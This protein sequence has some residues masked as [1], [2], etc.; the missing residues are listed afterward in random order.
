[1][2][3]NLPELFKEKAEEVSSNVFTSQNINDE[4]NY[5]IRVLEKEN[6]RRIALSGVDDLYKEELL[7]H[8]FELVDRPFRDNASKI[9]AS[10]T[11]AIGGIAET[12]TIIVQSDSEDIRLATMLPDI[13]FALLQAS[14]I[15][16]RAEDMT[17]QMKDWFSGDNYTAFITGPSRTADIE[18]VLTLGAH[19]PIQL[20]IIIKQ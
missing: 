6:I 4:I 18:R 7:K 1:M 2:N 3:S 11:P 13:H 12:G 5:I 9:E 19:G 20:H 17:R 8:G 16:E 15:V 10:V 14:S